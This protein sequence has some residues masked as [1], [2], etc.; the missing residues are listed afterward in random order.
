[1][2]ACALRRGSLLGILYGKYLG[3]NMQAGTETLNK[4]V[5]ELGPNDVQKFLPTEE[6]ATLRDLLM[7]RCGIYHPDGDSDPE[8]MSP[9]RG[10]RHPG[11]FFCCNNRNFDAVGPA[12]KN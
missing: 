1:M 6:T 9:V 8:D 3:N 11:T 10:S 2:S 7:S 4:T 5:K 12:S